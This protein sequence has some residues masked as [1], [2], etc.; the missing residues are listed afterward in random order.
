MKGLASRL[1][2]PVRQLACLARPVMVRLGLVRW[3]S[4]RQRPFA[5]SKMSPEQQLVYRSLQSRP[6]AAI[7]AFAQW[8][9][10]SQAGADVPDTGTG[11]AEVDNAA[12]ASGKLGDCPLIVLTAGRSGIV[13]SD[14]TSAFHAVWVH[15]LQAD[16]ARLSTHGRQI[17][18][19]NSAHMIQFEA[20]EAVVDAVREVVTDLRRRR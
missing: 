19:G 17:I 14:A 13:E 5:P 4:S 9:H 10:G 3:M 11:N 2:K 16:L 6:T 18:I 12:R 1:P 7:T 8:C 20:P 15:Q